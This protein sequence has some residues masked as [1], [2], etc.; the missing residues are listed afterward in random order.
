MLRHRLVAGKVLGAGQ[1]GRKKKKRFVSHVIKIAYFL[2]YIINDNDP[3]TDITNT[4]AVK[5]T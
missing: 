3:V 1:I 5:F 4:G 2:N